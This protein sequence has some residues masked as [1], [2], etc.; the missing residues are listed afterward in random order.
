MNRVVQMP[1]SLVLAVVLVAFVSP[2]GSFIA[3]VKIADNNAHKLQAQAQEAEAR[4]AAQ[5]RIL[6]CT[7][8][9]SILDAYDE[10]PPTTAAGKKQEKAWHELYTVS[11]CQP[12]R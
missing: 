1:L 5:G 10:A 9:S 2:I 11:Q 3:S 7:L 12:P 6:A 4:Q 8:F